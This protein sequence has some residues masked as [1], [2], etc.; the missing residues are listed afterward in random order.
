ME[1]YGDELL[2]TSLLKNEF[3]ATNKNLV[4]VEGNN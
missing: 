4:R 2:V 1:A 3:L